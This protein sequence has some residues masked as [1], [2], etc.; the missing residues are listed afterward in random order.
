MDPKDGKQR[1]KEL[2]QEWRTVGHVPRDQQDDLR[3]RFRA[4]CDAVFAHAAEVARARM[5]NEIRRRYEHIAKIQ[6]Q[7]DNSQDFIS[8]LQ[9]QLYEL[10][11]S[12]RNYYERKDSLES[13]ISEVEGQ[14]RE[15][16]G[17]IADHHRVIDEINSKLR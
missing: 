7:I 2:Q 12:R 15:K 6:N 13:K 16:E 3:D 14:I 4:A 5:E 11:S 17:W 10:D 8:R 1:I 9:S